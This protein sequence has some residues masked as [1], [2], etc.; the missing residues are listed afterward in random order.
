[1]INY[2]IVSA[3]NASL[4]FVFGSHRGL[5]DRENGIYFRRTGKVSPTFE[6]KRDTKTILGNRAHQKTNFRW[7]GG[8]GDRGTRPFISGEQ[9]DRYPHHSGRASRIYHL[10]NTPKHKKL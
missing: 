9:G 10:L 6:G 2:Y 1:M 3:H 4:T 8:D 7:G 5:G